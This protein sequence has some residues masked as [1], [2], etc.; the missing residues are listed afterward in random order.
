MGALDK[1]KKFDSI[2]I[3]EYKSGFDFREANIDDEE[4]INIVNEK[5]ERLKEN[6]LKNHNSRKEI[7]KTLYEIQE[8]MAKHGSGIFLK[9]LDYIQIKK[10]MAYNLINNWKLFTSTNVN[11]VFELPYRTINEI[12]KEIK[13]NEDLTTNEII[14]IIEDDIPEKR[15]QEIKDLRN[16]T[17]NNAV[18]NI[19]KKIQEIDKKIQSHYRKINKLEDEKNNLLNLFN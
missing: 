17:L 12:S 6:L 13:N 1:K 18:G 19:E 16:L 8:T 2:N 9:Y 7:A 3:V 14:E 4:T 5:E 15:I 11:K 10:T